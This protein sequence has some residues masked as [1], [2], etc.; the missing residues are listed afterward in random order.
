MIGAQTAMD[1][2]NLRYG[3][4]HR[5]IRYAAW[6]PNAEALTK[7]LCSQSVGASV[8][9]TGLGLPKDEFRH[10]LERHFPA[11]RAIQDMIATWRALPD[12]WQQPEREELIE[13]V[14]M[15]RA[16]RD[17][18]EVW[19]AHIVVTACMGTRHLWRDIGL[20]NRS[21]LTSLLAENFPSFAAKNAHDMKWKKFLY[22]QL[23]EHNQLMLCRAPSCQLCSDYSLCFGSE[24]E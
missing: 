8:L 22:K 24:E 16:H 7:I 14:L 17:P 5:L 10:M 13:L 4:Y 20:W 2:S 23:C 11:H 1:Q 3:L 18:S 19:M 6:L 9:P 12:A 15:H 21:D